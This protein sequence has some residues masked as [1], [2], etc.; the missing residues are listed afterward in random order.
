MQEYVVSKI[1]DTTI[2]YRIK[3]AN[4]MFLRTHTVPK[5]R[6]SNL[7][8]PEFMIYWNIENPM[9]VSFDIKFIRRDQK[10]RRNGEVCRARLM[11]FWYSPT[12]LK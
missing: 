1:A 5:I 7:L 4:D 8:F 9:L 6:S 2:L 12:D 10:Q 11:C 3:D